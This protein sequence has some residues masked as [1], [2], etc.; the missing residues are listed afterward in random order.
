MREKYDPPKMEATPGNIDT[1]FEHQIIFHESLVAARKST[2]RGNDPETLRILDLIEELKNMRWKARH[3][4]YTPDPLDRPE[5]KSRQ[6][7]V[8]P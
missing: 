1:F 7:S 5:K 2:N 3:I 4:F 6:P 8:A